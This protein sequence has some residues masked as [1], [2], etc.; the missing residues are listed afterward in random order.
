[1]HAIFLALYDGFRQSNFE[2]IFN[3]SGNTTAPSFDKTSLKKN[4]SNIPIARLGR[5]LIFYPLYVI[6]F[7]KCTRIE[8]SQFVLIYPQENIGTR[9]IL[10]DDGI[11]DRFAQGRFWIFKRLHSFKPLIRNGPYKVFVFQYFQYSIRHVKDVP[12]HNILSDKIGR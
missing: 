9:I 3:N 12:F 11:Q 6:P 4:F 8:E 2:T 10:M 5:M 1:M 7:R